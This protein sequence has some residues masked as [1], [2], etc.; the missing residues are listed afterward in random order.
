MLIIRNISI[1]VPGNKKEKRTKRQALENHKTS[2][3]RFIPVD[4]FK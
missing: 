2:E 4:I 1:C 3:N